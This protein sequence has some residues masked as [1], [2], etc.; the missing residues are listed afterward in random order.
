MASDPGRRNAAAVAI[1]WICFVLGVGA[2]GLG[3]SLTFVPLGVPTRD[4]V[5]DL[6]NSLALTAAIAIVAQFLVRIV[7]FTVR[8]TQ[9]RR[10]WRDFIKLALRPLVYFFLTAMILTGL[11]GAV[12]RGE[13]IYFWGIPLPF[14]DANDL[15]EQL[16]TAHW[17]VAYLLAGSILASL[18]AA[19]VNFFVMP[20]SSNGGPLRA[21]PQPSFASIATVIAE[22]LAQK[23]RFFGRFA[24]WLQFLL[25]FLSAAMLA[26]LKFD[27]TW[28]TRR[29]AMPVSPRAVLPTQCLT[30]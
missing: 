5:K 11:L 20:A 21:A 15:S 14:W 2:L 10:N 18:V 13:R 26:W 28:R 17:I 8:A 16:Q 6:H 7:L 22:R 19:I 12:L 3:W 9:G 1:Y 30:P 23:F 4:Y 29:F 25:G 24:F 27:S